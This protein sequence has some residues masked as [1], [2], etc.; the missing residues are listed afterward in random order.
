MKILPVLC[1]YTVRC[2]LQKLYDLQQNLKHR[3]EGDL[4][5]LRRAILSFG[6]RFPLFVWRARDNKQWILDGHGRLLVLRQLIEQ[7]YRF[8]YPDGAISDE[9]P[10]IMIQAQDRKQAYQ[11]LLLLNSAFGIFREDQFVRLAQMDADIFDA[12]DS[13]IKAIVQLPSIDLDSILQ[14][15]KAQ[16]D[17]DG[18][19]D[20]FRQNI[21]A[22][23]SSD[24]SADA[25][26][27]IDSIDEA[28][29]NES[30]WQDEMPSHRFLQCPS[31]G[32]ALRAS[33]NG[34]FIQLEMMQNENSI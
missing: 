15:V 5:K 23:R 31:C 13:D 22:L 34:K 24:S 17:F 3:S 26:Q 28:Q 29:Q 25:A 2:D 21:N 30:E 16:D 10:A 19:F 1:E 7:G 27:E 18:Y 6:M 20:R 14:L 32:A 4:D 8:Q 9:A 11:L 12:I 33:F